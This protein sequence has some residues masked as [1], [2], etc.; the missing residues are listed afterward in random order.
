M[1]ARHNHLNLH[2]Y[3]LCKV[4]SAYTF[5]LKVKLTVIKGTCMQQK[6]V[7]EHA[8]YERLL[9]LI[10]VIKPGEGKATLLLTLNACLL[11]FSYYLLKVIREPLILAY[12]GAEYKSYATAMQAGVLLI[13]IPIF[14]AFY[15]RFAEHEKRSTI[16]CRVFYFFV[17]NLLFFALCQYLGLNIGM[18]F[19]VWLGIFSVM[20]V[21]QFWGFAADLLNVKSGQRL[22][23]ILAVGATLGAW[24]GSKITGPIF[25]VVGVEGVIFLAAII[26]LFSIKITEKVEQHIPNEAMNHEPIDHDNDANQWLDGFTVVFRNNYLLQIAAFVMILVFINSTGE[27]VLAR[28]VSEHSKELIES[29]AIKSISIWQGQFYSSYY[30]WVTLGSFLLQLFFVSR[31]FKWFGISGSIL[32]L[33]I[34]MIIGYGL[35][36]FIPI[37]SI[38]RFAMIAENSANYSIQNTT[39]HA[40]FLPVPRK[41]KYLG[42]TTIETF[43]FRFGDLLYGFFILIGVEFFK[44]EVSTF[45]L[46]NLVLA[47]ILFGFA[48]KVGHTNKVEVQKTQGNSPPQLMATIPRLYMPSGCVAKFSISEST[49]YDPDIGDALSYEAK[50]ESGKPLPKWI[51]F[52]KMSRDFTFYP[53]DDFE[54]QFNL[55]V[56]ARDF[57]GL[58][59]STR[60][61]LYFFLPVNDPDL[62]TER[63]SFNE[64]IVIQSN[65]SP[66]NLN[67]S[68]LSRTEIGK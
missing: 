25:P 62:Y 9:N 52:D 7:T 53:P 10:S 36:F 1:A 43:F 49:F 2:F 21:A 41:L 65:I 46:T 8:W 48:W 34:V 40:L 66:A 6:V 29:G 17:V 30:A 59:A 12:G 13:L 4:L 60:I 32:I 57:E 50:R 51:K 5:H 18:A 61:K 16:I 47:I 27:Y 14:S 24:L 11:M 26:L 54:G 15:H 67:T 22:F 3:M 55:V 45:I 20:V 28:L 63:R 44:L 33:P 56:V 35:M 19:Y 58:T 42:K 37:F 68:N 64:K 39:K 23:V 38:V 31:L